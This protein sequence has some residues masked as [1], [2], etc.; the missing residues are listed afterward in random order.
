M[1]EIANFGPLA[2]PTS[3]GR[4]Y[5]LFNLRSLV[6]ISDKLNCGFRFNE[7]VLSRIGAITNFVFP[8]IL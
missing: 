5:Q 7:P 8:R 1:K 2:W 6:E 3:A 4:Y